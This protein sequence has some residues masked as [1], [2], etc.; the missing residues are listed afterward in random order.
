MRKG[1]TF[2]HEDLMTDATASGVKVDSMCPRERFNVRIFSQILG[3]FVLNV[4]IKG[5]NGLCG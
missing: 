4:V 5:E 1:V 3:R 2:F